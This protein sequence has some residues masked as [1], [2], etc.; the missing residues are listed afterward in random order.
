[1]SPATCLFAIYKSQKNLYLRQRFINR[2][3]VC[4][5]GNN[6]IAIWRKMEFL[7]WQRCRRWGRGIDCIPKPVNN[8]IIIP[9]QRTCYYLFSKSRFKVAREQNENNADNKSD[10]HYWW[11][12]RTQ[13]LFGS[14]RNLSLWLQLRDEHKVRPA[15][16]E[17]SW[18]VITRNAKGQGTSGVA[19][20]RRW[21]PE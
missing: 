3:L 2:R 15:W 10:C 7:K 5:M 18:D 1:M 14:S 6:C 12:A 21:G 11:M 4:R 13:A 8:R 16:D 20:K 9:L 17:R 19:P